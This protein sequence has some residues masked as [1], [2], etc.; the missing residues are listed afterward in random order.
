MEVDED[1]FLV[2]AAVY[3]A[4][5]DATGDLSGYF[6][7]DDEEE[8]E[9]EATMPPAGQHVDYKSYDMVMIGVMVLLWMVFFRPLCD[10]YMR[11]LVRFRPIPAC[12]QSVIHCI[13]QYVHWREIP[14]SIQQLFSKE[15]E[16]YQRTT[17]DDPSAA[18]LRVVRYNQE[19]AL[20]QAPAGGNLHD[21]Y[22]VTDGFF[23]LRHSRDLRLDESEKRILR[24]LDPTV[25][26]L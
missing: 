16:H 10:H 6:F 26:F 14:T 17:P 4:V 2:E 8:K 3:D 9:V 11:L 5:Y 25:G 13:Q 1:G 18:E 22:I 12:M 20:A 23:D 21:A 15:P 7:P 24:R 19:G